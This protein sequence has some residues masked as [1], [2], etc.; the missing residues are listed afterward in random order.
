MAVKINDEENSLL[1]WLEIAAAISSL[2]GTAGL[3]ALMAQDVRA[4]EPPSG[5]QPGARTFTNPFAN[6]N[7]PAAGGNFFD[8]EE[9]EDFSPPQ[10]NAPPPAPGGGFPPPGSAAPAPSNG[11]AGISMGG[12][13]PSGVI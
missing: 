8:D 6:Q 9:D 12:T 11:G 5:F 10:R 7:P 4:A 2:I 1:L 3:I 13:P